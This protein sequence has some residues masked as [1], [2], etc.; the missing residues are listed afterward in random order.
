[1]KRELT[2]KLFGPPKVVFQQ[3]DIRFSFSKMEALFYYLAVSGEVNRDEIAGILWGDKENQVARKNLRNTV[4]Q[5]NKIFEGDVIVSPSRS[6]LA[7]NPELNLS[8]DVQLFER[9]P[10]SNLH[11]YQGDFL[12][13]FYVKDDEDFDQWASR[14]RSAYKQLYIESCYQKIDKEG[15]GD[16]G[17]ESLLHHLVE[18][19]EFE[20]KNYQLLMEYYR[21][22]HQLGK[23]FETYYKLVDLLD[24]ELNVR[25]SRVIEEL[26]HSVLEAKRTRKQS[27]RV[28]VRELPFFGRKQELSQLEEYLSLVEKGEAVGPLLVMGQSGT[29]KKRLLRQLVLLSNRSFS[30]VKL[31]GKVGSRQEEG[32]IWDDLK[33]SLEKVSGGLEAPPL[34]KADNLPAVRKH[35][36][37]LSQEKPLL[38]LLEN[39]QWMDAASFNK[40][41][42][43][44]EKSSGE[45]WQ[46]IV[47]AEGPL[48]EFLL[49]FFGSLKVER[50][51]SQLELTNFDP[52]ESRLL[53]Q[54]QLGQIEP[55]LIEQMMEWSEGSPF[56]L[57]SYIEEWK[58]K[59]SLEPLPDIIQA[60]LSQELGD[61]SSEE[62]SLLH[63]L[64]C[65]H[66]PISMSILADLT[67]TD[68][69]VLTAL[70]DPLT[71][72]GII[73]IVEEGE[74]LLVQFC[75][76]LVAM[77]FYQLLSPARRRLFHQQIAQKLEETLEDSTDLLFY[78]EIAYQYKQSQN[79]LRSL[80]FELTYL[81]EILQL[82][83][84][85]F[86]IYSKGEEGGVSD[87]KNSHLDIFGELSRLRRE[88]DQLFSRHQKDRDY[89]YLQL[90]YLYLEGRYFIRSG[91]YQKGIHDIQKVISYARELKQ[92]DFLLEGY[93]QII[94]YCIQ[95]ENISE[96]AYY[97]DLVLEDAI[98]ANNHE[99]I[100]IQLRLKGL[101]HLMVGDEEQATRHLYRSID[102]FSLTNSM[103]AKYAI[104][105]AASLAYLAEIEQVR[106]H[107][108]VAVTHLEEVLRLV[109]DQSV[110]SVRVV[111]EIDLGIAY[112]WKGDLVQARLYFDRAQ[113]VL[114]SVRFPWKEE[115]LEFYQALIACHFGEQEKVAHYLARKEGTIKQATHSRDKGMV[116]YLLAFLSAQK[117]QGEHLNPPLSIFLREDKNYYKKLAEQHLTPYRDRPF[118]KRLKVL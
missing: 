26:Y 81:E 17:I 51:L 54:G 16:P 66:K 1:M 43:L 87:G 28:N 77:Y 52:S 34:G 13:G 30:F 27:N 7:L 36:Q 94:Y 55:A 78:K 80:S 98:Q 23:F 31:E 69:S 90:R 59:E 100:A 111:F 19:D 47:T 12:E 104:Q 50:R 40:V 91:E 45:R 79:L 39:A 25:P 61:L 67:A 15:L 102:C 105:I 95:T 48:P 11:L 99:A 93:R 62:E 103:Q 116:Y 74:D 84:E 4:Y 82:E 101:Y 89:K 114:S 14:K 58:E 115:L 108:Q 106:G 88:L 49:T 44:E 42:Q 24:R 38:I 65:F 56:L 76:Q 86:P 57:S 63:Y 41:K 97:T 46:L 10:I 3:K 32:G 60:Y 112:Y 110:D 29:G 8:L 92:L 9:D 117:E 22:H 96:M 107:F 85:L 68:L 71:Q 5:A 75:K 64:S 70:L 21:V 18:L 72:R 118:L 109:G 6:S 73:S 53:L 83:H 2:L 20:E 113:K 33:A 35:L 37:R